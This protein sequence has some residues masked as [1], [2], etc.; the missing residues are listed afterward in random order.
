MR[1]ECAPRQ[2]PFGWR[3]CTIALKLPSVL[4]PVFHW[5]LWMATLHHRAETTRHCVGQRLEFLVPS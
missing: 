3:R 1:A 5:N 4:K 2:K